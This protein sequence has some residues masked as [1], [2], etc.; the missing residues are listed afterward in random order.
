MNEHKI[1]LK[2]RIGSHCHGTN[3]PESDEDIRGIFIPPI[4]Y[5]L[6][7]KEIEQF[8]GEGKDEE[9]WN[10]KKFFRLAII[11]NLSALNIIFTREKDILDCDLIGNSILVNRQMFISMKVIDSIHGYC[12]SQLHKMHIGKGTK[13]HG[14][15]GDRTDLIE[16]Y[17]YDTKFAYHALMLTFLGIDILKTGTYRTYLP[18]GQQKYVM[19]IRRG[20]TKYEDCMKMIA[21]NLT[22]MK[23][24]EP[25]ERIPK[26]PDT[27]KINKFLV[28]T[29]EGYYE[30]VKGNI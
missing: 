7:L 24:L 12:T 21:G 17:G 19:S 28:S 3:T 4:E 11:G 8:K 27:E 18:D 29:L 22:V 5:Y 9:Y 15:T 20:E 23:T 30:H 14:R 6:G 26:E 2:T 13:G 10:I 1:I 16:K 25:L